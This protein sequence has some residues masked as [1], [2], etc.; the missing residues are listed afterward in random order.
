MK[1]Q[2]IYRA[3]TTDNEPLEDHGRTG[4]EIRVNVNFAHEQGNE[5]AFK[6]LLNLPQFQASLE[7]RFASLLHS[8]I[9]KMVGQ[10]SIKPGYGWTDDFEVEISISPRESNVS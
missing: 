9:Q 5:E 1:I 4:A 3:G 8:E 7:A 10:S 6:Q 2:E